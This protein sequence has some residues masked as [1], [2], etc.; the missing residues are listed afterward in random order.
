MPEAGQQPLTAEPKHPAV[1]GVHDS[2]RVIA[3]HDGPLPCDARAREAG[4]RDEATVRGESKCA[5]SA[6]QV[7]A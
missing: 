1:N 4:V 7:K 5:Q 2:V 3:W 6:S